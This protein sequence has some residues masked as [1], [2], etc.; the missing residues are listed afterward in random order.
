MNP[1]RINQLTTRAFENMVGIAM[2]NYPG[3]K[4]GNSYRKVRAYKKLLD[5]KVDE[6][7]IR[8]K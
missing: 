3:D 1:A 7:S 4:W 2:A 8:D 6:P 5:K